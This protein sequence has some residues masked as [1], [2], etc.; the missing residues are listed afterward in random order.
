MA[1]AEKENCYCVKYEGAQLDIG[2]EFFNG[3]FLH[4]L[5]NIV[6]RLYQH[7]ATKKV[8]TVAKDDE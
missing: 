6:K 4:D 7:V 1:A 2:Q 5:T 8:D 3:E